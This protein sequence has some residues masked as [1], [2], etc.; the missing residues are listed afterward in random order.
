MIVDRE[1][2]NLREIKSIGRSEVVQSLIDNS[3][4]L[5]AIWVCRYLSTYGTISGWRYFNNSLF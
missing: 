2:D 5:D 3:G 1:H 4:S